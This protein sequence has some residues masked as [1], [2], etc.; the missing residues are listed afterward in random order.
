MSNL[1]R[2]MMYRTKDYEFASVD[3]LRRKEDQRNVYMHR[4][5]SFHVGDSGD[6]EFLDRVV[7]VENP[8]IVVV[9]TGT[10]TPADSH[11]PVVKD[12][13]L[14]TS[15]V[16]DL[17]HIHGY[18]IVRLVPDFDVADMGSR[19]MW[20]HVESMVFDVGGTVL[21]LPVCFGRRGHGLF[22]QA[23]REIIPG[24]CPDGWEP[25]KGRR[26]YAYAED[27]ASMLWFIMENPDVHAPMDP[28]VPNMV[29]MPAIGYASPAEMVAMAHPILGWG[30]HNRLSAQ[31]QEEPMLPNWVPDSKDM[32][33]AVL[34]TAQWYKMNRWI[35]NT[36]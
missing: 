31:S 18:R 11:W 19:P 25:D 3:P 29:R 15:S 7:R 2:Y 26:R 5:H 21:R 17:H 8:D 6:P 32:A 22:E 14:P 9:G 23:L 12:I 36:Q 13:V 35:F 24:R 33:D 27:V 10:P 4:R 34:K 1:M 30:G 20:N 16:C 28:S